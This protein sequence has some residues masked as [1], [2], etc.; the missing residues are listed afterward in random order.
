MSITL[1]DI[2]PTHEGIIQKL[3]ERSP[4]EQ[5]NNNY[6]L[7]KD[8]SRLI[9][10]DNEIPIGYM[11]CDLVTTR[12]TDNGVFVYSLVILPSYISI[13]ASN[14]SIVLNYIITLAQST[15]QKCITL[16][17]PWTYQTITPT[18]KLL[19]RVM[20]IGQFKPEF[21]DLLEYNPQEGRTGTKKIPLKR[22]L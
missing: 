13:I 7:K 3:N 16:Y 14:V 4:K 22:H 6:P 15:H 12:K 10:I 1:D 18:N 19:Q 2:Y 5:Q 17:L 21:E 9:F 11:N 8:Y 20:Q